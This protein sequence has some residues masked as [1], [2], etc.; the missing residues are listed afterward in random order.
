VNLQ[1]RI[2]KYLAGAAENNPLPM[3]F[4][5]EGFRATAMMN[6]VHE[7]KLPSSLVTG[8]QATKFAIHQERGERVN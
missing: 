5:N 2:L 4:S 8:R 6:R 3:H 1:P 7:R